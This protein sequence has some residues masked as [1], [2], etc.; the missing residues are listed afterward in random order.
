MEPGYVGMSRNEIVAGAT[1]NDAREGQLTG[2]LRQVGSVDTSDPEKQ[3]A[4]P[5]RISAPV[6]ASH[7]E[8]DPGYCHIVARLNGGWRVIICRD[9]LQWILQY[10]R[11][12]CWR[13]RRFCMTSAALQREAQ[14]HCGD[15]DP[16]ALKTLLALP[17]HFR[18]CRPIARALWGRTVPS[19]FTGLK[20]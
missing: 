9:G 11:S 4:A 18:D 20:I 13:N 16:G 10:W 5:D 17:A 3:A 6:R 14:T 7:R 19:G 12:P 1:I 8:S 2:S 15:I